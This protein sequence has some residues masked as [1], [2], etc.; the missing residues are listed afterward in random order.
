MKH[1]TGCRKDLPL[2]AFSL[3]RNGKA[4]LSQC[5]KCAAVRNAAWRAQ[6]KAMAVAKPVHHPDPLNIALRQ[7]PGTHGRLVGAFEWSAV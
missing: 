1:C 3:R 5:K 4:A 7:M 2:S 6:Q